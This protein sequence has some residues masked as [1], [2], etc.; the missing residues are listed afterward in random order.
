MKYILNQIEVTMKIDLLKIS[1][2]IAGC[3]LI[4]LI[5]SFFTRSSVKSAWY[6][7]LKKPVIQPP[8]WVFAPVWITLFCMMGI[9]FYLVWRLEPNAARDLAITFFFVQLLFNILWSF[10]FFYLKNPLLALIEIVVLLLLIAITTLLFYR[11]S[12]LAAYWMLPYLIWVGYATVLNLFIV[13][14]N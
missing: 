5:G 12:R 7:T 3:Q 14:L 2:S 13:K 4:G 8:D 11:I 9:A 6:F 1:L 10:L